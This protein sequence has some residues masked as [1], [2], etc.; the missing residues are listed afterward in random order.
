MICFSLINREGCSVL[1]PLSPPLRKRVFMYSCGKLLTGGLNSGK[2]KHPLFFLV[3]PSPPR[4]TDLANGKT[5]LHS[6]KTAWKMETQP[7]SGQ[8]QGLTKCLEGQ[9]RDGNSEC[10]QQGLLQTAFR[11]DSGINRVE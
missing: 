5:D 8:L 2:R 4:F 6:L 3:P 10:F 9:Q 11:L 7:L 1:R